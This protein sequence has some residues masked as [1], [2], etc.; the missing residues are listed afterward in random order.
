MLYVLFMMG[1]DV[2]GLLEGLPSAQTTKVHARTCS[3]LL[4]LVIT[5]TKLVPEIEAARPGCSSGI[6]ALC[7][8]KN[9]I[10]TA[11]SLLQH[12]SESS[13]LYLVLTGDAIVS[14]CKNLR[15][16][17]SQSLGKI[18]NMVPVVLAAKISGIIVDLRSAVFCLDPP[19]EES[20][21]LLRELLH[22]YGSTIDST[23]DA[24]ISVLR[25]VSTWLHI[26]SRKA[27]SIEKR[28]IRKLLDR[29]GEKPSKRKVLLLFLTLL[30][31]YGKFMANE[32]K[33]NIL[34]ELEEPSSPV[35]PYS[36]SG[37]VESHLN[38]RPDEAQIDMF[39]SPVPPDEFICPLTSRLMYDP[40]TI[41]SGHTYER[42]WIWKWFDEGNDTCPKTNMKLEHFSFTSNIIIKEQILKW[43]AMHGVLIHEPKIQDK[44]VK[45][46]EASANSI[47]SL[48]SSMNDLNLPYDFR[49]SFKSSSTSCSS[50][51][52]V[53][54]IV[55]SLHEI[56]V[57]FFAKFSSLP[58]D[59]QCNAIEDVKRL[60]E[61]NYASVI[62]LEEFIQ[63][64]VRFL[65]DAL[66]YCDVEAQMSGCVVL[67]EF[68]QKD[69]KSMLYL[70]QD[71]YGIL[72]S[73]LDTKAANQALALLE[74]LS[75]HQHSGLKFST[76][77]ALVRILNILDSPSQE[78]LEPAL[79][80]LSNLSENGG[81]GSSIT[82]SEIIAKLAP[83]LEDDNLSRYCTVTLKNLC[84]TEEARVSIAETRG[85]ISAVAKLLEN[86]SRDVQECAVSILHSLCT[87]HA[88]YCEL[89]MSEAVVPSLFLVSRNG[90]EKAKAM[91][92]EI[93]RIPGE[94]I[95]SA[96]E[97]SGSDDN[98]D[99][100]KPFKVP[101]SRTT[102][103]FGKI[104]SRRS[105][106]N[107]KLNFNS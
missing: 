33:H 26:T 56:D 86:K 31:N 58:W 82:P 54:S 87:K 2:T 9:D 64:L 106:K 55:N 67:L 32:Q 102:G 42:A 37:D 91:A 73:F 25:S 60:C 19:E 81:L 17:L 65:K 45:M 98:K 61:T 27:L 4:K 12:C 57:E 62:P 39:S 107:K 59:Y 96:V 35:S 20:G 104:L 52:K 83:L 5:V 40:V 34:A 72:A 21:K 18:Q 80:I 41:V 50:H 51:V 15:N 75:F 78:L 71:S 16:L 24:A 92:S 88:L 3:E 6:E 48:S 74:A 43:C 11:K 13:V 8:L 105:A 69:R 66:D 36:I 101:G 46:W 68:V 70:D 90:N 79:K 29:C 84:D 76:S 93:L 22:R 99:S 85:C 103:F 28:S 77:G 44:S 1:N 95:C 94:G 97:N 53:L 63:L 30:N 89:V 49:M 38:F 14:K 10:D 23:E 47:T 100:T 7:L